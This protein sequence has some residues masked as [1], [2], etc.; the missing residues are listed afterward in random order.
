M[1][2]VCFHP[3]PSGTPSC[4]SVEDLELL[5][6]IRGFSDHL[7]LSLVP[8][9][10]LLDQPL[11]VYPGGLDSDVITMD[12]SADSRAS[13]QFRHVLAC[14]LRK[15]TSSKKPPSSHSVLSSVTGAVQALSQQRTLPT[16]WS[17][18]VSIGKLNLDS[19]PRLRTEV[20]SSHG[21]HQEHCLLLVA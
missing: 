11:S 17:S 18:S 12:R 1:T 15:P 3:K 9:S 14:P 5:V 16:A 7:R 20:R 13:G 4:R 19:A 6:Q 8:F 21:N 10:E 2:R